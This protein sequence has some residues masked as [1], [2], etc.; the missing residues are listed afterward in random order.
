MEDFINGNI[1]LQCTEVE[2]EHDERLIHESFLT[3]HELEPSRGAMVLDIGLLLYSVNE[4]I[5]N[6]KI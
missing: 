2:D 3:Q 6:V 5:D 4:L 1:R